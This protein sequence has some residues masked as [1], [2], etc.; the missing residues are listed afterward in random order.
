MLIPRISRVLLTKSSIRHAQSFVN[1]TQTNLYKSLQ[2]K[3]IDNTHLTINLDNEQIRFDWIFLRDSCQC[4][5]C[6]DSSSKQKLHHL[7][8]IPWNISPQQQQ[9]VRILNNSILE[10]LWNHSFTNEKFHRSLYPST[11]LRTYSSSKTI[12]QSRFHDR[13]MIYWTRKHLEHVNLHVTCDEYLHTDQGL[14]TALKHLNDYGLVFLDNVQGEFTVERLVERIG[15]IRN[16]FYGKSWNVKNVEQATNV[17]YTSQALGLHMDLLYFEAPPGLQ[18]LHSLK[19][20][21][22]GGESYYVDSFHAAEIVRKEDPE[23]FQSLCSYPVTFHYRNVNRHYHRTRPTIVLN[24]FSDDSR[25]DHV[26]YSPPFQAPFETDTSQPEFRTFLRAFRRFHEL[27][28]GEDKRLEMILQE[29]QCVIFH[30]RRILHARRA[31]DSTSGQRWLKGCYTDL[32]N[33]H[34]RWRIFREKFSIN[35]STD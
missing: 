20:N 6:V 29:N 16:T 4:S 34:D 9:G 13:P 12:A 33:F 21:V 1:T 18:F 24:Q 25:I 14:Y 5:Q 32:D 17:A 23:A 10:I 7:A 19:N 26:N 15:E 27:L 2:L 28:E 30:N 35:T 8:D 31:F 22:Q 3:S 11:W